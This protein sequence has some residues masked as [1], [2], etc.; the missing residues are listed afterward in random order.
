VLVASG[1]DGG[2][3]T[4]SY[5]SADGTVI[6]QKVC[7]TIPKYLSKSYRLERCAIQSNSSE[8]TDRVEIYIVGARDYLGM[9]SPIDSVGGISKCDKEMPQIYNMM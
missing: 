9:T 6:S 2:A 7:S 8:F 4:G 1:I 5:V 3:R